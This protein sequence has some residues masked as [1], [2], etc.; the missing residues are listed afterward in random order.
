MIRLILVAIFLVLFLVLTLPLMLIGWILKKIVPH[1]GDVFCLAIVSWGFR[2]IKWLSGVKLTVIGHDKIPRDRNLLYVGNHR[3][4]F[5]TVLTYPL[6]VGPTG[7][8]AKKEMLKAPILN[9]WMVLLHCQFLDRKDT[10]AGLKVILNSIELEKKGISMAVFPEGTRNK[11][12]DSDELLPMHNGSFK[13]ATK[14]D[15]LIVPMAICG[16]HNILE[17][18]APR[19]KSTRVI[20]E[21]CDPIDPKTLTKEQQKDLGS[22]ISEILKETYIKNKKLLE[23]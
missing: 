13:V 10:R 17:A 3:G 14:S 20:I 5:D 22:Y 16:S 11:N 9:L 12:Y 23:A 1:T 21:Y 7:Y 18:Q 8:I 4:L 2:V 6:V 15:A 19:I